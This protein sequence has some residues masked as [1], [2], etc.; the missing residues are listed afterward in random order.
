MGQHTRVMGQHTSS[1][2]LRVHHSMDEIPADAWD[3]LNTT[4][5]PFHRHAFLRALEHW[6]GVEPDNGWA[7]H[8]LAL[9]DDSDVLLAAAP[10]YLKGHSWGEFVFDFA[11]ADAFE[12]NGRAYYPKMI[13][14]VPLTPA[15]GPRVLHGP[16]IG[17]TDALTALAGA[18]RELIAENALSSMH[19]LF[20]REPDTDTLREAGYSERLGIQYHWYNQGYRDFD[21]FLDA[22]TS[23][24]RKNIRRERRK[25]AES[26]VTLEVKH[27]AEVTAEEWTRFHAFYEDTFDRRGNVPLLSPRFFEQAGRALDWRTVLILARDRG[28]MVAAA[29]C[30]RD[31]DTLYGRYWGSL[32][33]EDSL[34]FEACYYQGIDYCIRHGLQRFEPGAQGE[35][36]IPRGF[37]PTLT[38]SCHWI[39]EPGFRAG[40]DRFLSREREAVRE[41]FKLL[42]AHS[43]FKAAEGVR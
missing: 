18:A 23:K 27:G 40:I 28:E 11:W 37:L 5:Y 6:G 31:A 38:H 43:P 35:H 7:P 21:D 9:Y 22:L 2:R 3:T 14:A 15:T 41:R 19:W 4:D 26:P 17:R 25:V 13:A 36:K 20:P 39:E 16:G 42:S 30:Y 8:H 24:K 33:Y 1:M 12:R 10:A 29:L 34:H 32:G